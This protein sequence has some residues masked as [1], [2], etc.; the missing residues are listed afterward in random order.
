[1]W[2]HSSC[3]GVSQVE[4]EKDD[5]HFVCRDCKRK[6]EDAQKPKIPPLKFKLGSSSSPPSDKTIHDTIYVN[7]NHQSQ[8]RKSSDSEL[9][10]P[11]LPQMKK[12]KPYFAPTNKASS[13]PHTHLHDTSNNNSMHQSLM[14]G[15]TLSPEG[16]LSHTQGVNEP[17]HPPPGLLSPTRDGTHANGYHQDHLNHGPYHSQKYSAP[18]KKGVAGFAKTT[19]G[20]S[21]YQN[22]HNA[23]AGYHQGHLVQPSDGPF[24]N[25]F[26][27]Q[28]PSSSYLINNVPSPVKNHPPVSPTQELNFHSSSPDTPHANGTTP[29]RSAAAAHP[30]SYPSVRSGLPST[31]AASVGASSS[32]VIPPPSN[33][34]QS[35]LAGLSPSKHSPPRPSPSYSISGTPVVPP[36]AQLFPSPQMQNLH[37]PVKG[38]TPEQAK[39]TPA[40]LNGQ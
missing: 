33:Q 23:Q 35:S 15:P 29:H 8:K 20:Y 34:P 17:I 26:D 9:G 14:N 28:R 39:I 38:L 37:A 12:F 32:P 18:P 13:T 25:S 6:Q 5:F 22:T 36:T 16:Q 4:A 27:R 3:L 11:G 31:P 40:E 21:A 7:G 10:A 2:Q 1:M 30:S 19:N 24:H